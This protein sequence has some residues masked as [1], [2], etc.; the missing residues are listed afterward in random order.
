[1]IDVY[2][3]TN[4]N[5]L[6]ARDPRDFGHQLNNRGSFLRFGKAQVSDELDSVEQI[7]V[8]PERLRPSRRSQ[9]LGSNTIFAE[10]RESMRAGVD[11]VL[12]IHGFDY[13]FH[14]ALIDAALLKR[15]Y[16]TAETPYTFFVFSWP[17][18]GSLMPYIAY[19][20]DRADARTSGAA[21]GR[22]LLKLG[23][24]VRRVSDELG[25]RVR[26][27]LGRDAETA[28][29]RKELRAGRLHL[30]AHSMGGYV[31]RHAVQG[32]RREIGDDLPRLF[33]EIL[34]IAVDEDADA[35]EH[36]HKLALLPRLARRVTVYHNREDIPLAISDMTKGNPDRLG[37]DGPSHPHLLPAKVSV[38]DCTEVVSGFQEHRYHKDEHSVT[39]DIMAVLHAN[40]SNSVANRTYVPESN[41]YQISRVNSKRQP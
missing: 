22:G 26:S 27:D 10:I 34:L 35:F 37:A 29:L 15:T 24:F 5:P 13:S 16:E 8:A 6:P 12:F 19:A 30:M 21:L 20:N 7:A 1:M 25:P 33:D 38:V 17:S 41:S 18:D 14:E 23:E 3:G 31:L 40:T 36:D 28:R 32:M 2:F 39:E 11:T 4:R 9:L